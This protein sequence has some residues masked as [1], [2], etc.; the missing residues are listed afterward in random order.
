MVTGR[1]SSGAW[2]TWLW[3]GFPTVLAL[4]LLLWMLDRIGCKEVARVALAIGPTGVFVLL[5][6]GVAESYLDAQA[7]R[8]GVKARAPRLAAF[9]YS[10]TGAL[11]N[12]LIPLEAGEAFKI[13]LVSRT[14]GRSDAAAGVLLWNYALKWCGPGVALVAVAVGALSPSSITG[15][16]LAAVVGA[17][18]LAMAPYLLLRVLLVSRVSLH[19]TQWALQRVLGGERASRWQ[20][21]ITTVHENLRNFRTEQPRHFRSLV[22]YQIAARIVAWVTLYAGARLMGLHY[23]FGTC[24]LIYASVN[25]T[26]YVTAILPARVGVSEGA[27]FIVFELIGLPGESGLLLVFV[28]RLKA[29]LS[30]GIGGLLAVFIR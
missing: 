16:T 9:A 15:R 26:S 23:S 7:L 17:S 11:I 19:F 30:N 27:A 28:L 13:A 6:L 3:R 2:R 24:S 8:H 20:S 21:S 18:V 5:A 14:A 29:L 22:S 25:V 4:A 12:W 10:A 1:R